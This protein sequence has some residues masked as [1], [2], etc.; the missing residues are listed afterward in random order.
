MRHDYILHTHTHPKK[1]TYAMCI[2]IYIHH[3]TQILAGL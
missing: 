2:Y 3:L 1:Y